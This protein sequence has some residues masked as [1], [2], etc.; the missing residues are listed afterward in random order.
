M[1]KFLLG[2]IGERQHG[3]GLRNALGSYGSDSGHRWRS[4]SSIPGRTRS[5][6]GD[7]NKDNL[8]QIIEEEKVR[9][10]ARY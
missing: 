4:L 8:R 3:K 9:F 2:L 6:C 10:F 5:V 1:K 7:F